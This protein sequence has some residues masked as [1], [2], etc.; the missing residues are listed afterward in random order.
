MWGRGGWSPLVKSGRVG[1]G[2]AVPRGAQE[3]ASNRKQPSCTH[4]IAHMRV[5]D[6]HLAHSAA[7]SSRGFE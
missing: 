3:A 2:A 6:S 7:S 5:A 1:E 4:A